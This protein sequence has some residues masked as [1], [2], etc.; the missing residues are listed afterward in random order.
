MELFRQF[1]PTDLIK[2]V[3]A[4]D[5]GQGDI[6]TA[7]TVAPDPSFLSLALVEPVP[8]RGRNQKP[9]GRL[10]LLPF[11][12]PERRSDLPAQLLAAA[13]PATRDTKRS[14]G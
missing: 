7:A 10:D 9:T 2:R 11:G 12:F 14:C 1:D 5:V 13:A 3:L 6:T 4:E 8:E